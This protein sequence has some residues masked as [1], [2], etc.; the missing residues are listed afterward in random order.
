MNK[1]QVYNILSKR[2][3]QQVYVPVIGYKNGADIQCLHQQERYNHIYKLLNSIVPQR[4][5]VPVADNS[6]HVKRACLQGLI[7]TAYGS[8][9]QTAG[10]K[11]RN[12]LL[13][14]RDTQYNP[15]EQSEQYKGPA[16][17]ASSQAQTASEIPVAEDTKSTAQ[18]KKQ[19]QPKKD[20]KVQAKTP[21]KPG[22]TDPWSRWGGKL[23][24][25][26]LGGLGLYGIMSIFTNSPILRALAFL[27]GA[28]AGGYMG[29]TY[30]AYKASRVPSSKVPGN[31]P[32]T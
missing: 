31:K 28:G 9:G 23:I 21:E 7:K 15:E 1:E 25:G 29:H 30:D 3:A 14:Y 27:F 24:G 10:S 18:S 2:A 20:P 4:K 16:Q 13:G 6:L 12:Q 32:T 11:H 22:T 8:G 17:D 26:G 19:T 5:P